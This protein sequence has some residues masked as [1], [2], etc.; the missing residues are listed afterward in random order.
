MIVYFV[1]TMAMR[2]YYDIWRGLVWSAFF[3]ASFL[4]IT[5]GMSNCMKW[6]TLPQA[7]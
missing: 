6:I 1:Q 3:H 2:E 4:L 7:V 5:P